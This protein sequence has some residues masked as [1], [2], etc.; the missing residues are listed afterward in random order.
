MEFWRRQGSAAL[1]PGIGVGLHLANEGL[2]ISVTGSL[3]PVESR[4]PWPSTIRR[5]PFSV[6]HAIRLN[7]KDASAYYLRGWAYQQKGD[8][9]KAE[10]EFAQAKKL[11]YKAK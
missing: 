5:V 3:R 9:A 4:S 8:K 1:W 6:T 7:P 10:E 2:S 11:G